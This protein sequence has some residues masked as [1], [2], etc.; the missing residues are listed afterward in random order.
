MG[1]EPKNKIIIVRLCQREVNGLTSV[2][3][4]GL[5]SARS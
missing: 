2:V 5:G 1:M 3:A 4:I